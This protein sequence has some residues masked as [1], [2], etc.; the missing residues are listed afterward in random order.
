MILMVHF[1]R[2][3]FIRSGVDL[4][5]TDDLVNDPLITRKTSENAG[6]EAHELSTQFGGNLRTSFATNDKRQPAETSTFLE[7][8]LGSHFTLQDFGI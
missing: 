6:N 7:P 3:P 4:G 1:I 2:D 8:R 5:S